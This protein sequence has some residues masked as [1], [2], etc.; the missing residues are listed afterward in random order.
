[1][2]SMEI[3]TYDVSEKSFETTKSNYAIENLRECVM[4]GTILN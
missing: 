2:S 1:M 4:E 3:I